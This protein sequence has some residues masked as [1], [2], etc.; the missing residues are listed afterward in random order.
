MSGRSYVIELDGSHYVLG[1][2]ARLDRVADVADVRGDKWVISDLQGAM[3]R[4]MPVEAP[5]RYV[6][7]PIK[8]ALQE[9]GEFGGSTCVLVHHKRAKSS[10]STEVFFTA[11]DGP[12]CDRYEEQVRADDDEHLL[13]S[14]NALFMAAWRRLSPA[15]PVALI[16]MHG[17]YLDYAIVGHGRVYASGRVSGYD[18]SLEALRGG[19]P[20]LD[21]DLAH[22]E[23]TARIAL[24]EVH[25]IPVLEDSTYR[26][27]VEEFQQATGRACK[28]WPVKELRVDDRSVF[29]ALPDLVTR[30]VIGDSAV[31]P[32][33]KLMAHAKRWVMPALVAFG[34]ASGGLAVG[35]YSLDTKNAELRARIEQRMAEDAAIGQPDRIRSANY[36]EIIEFAQELERIRHAPTLQRI[37]NDL[38][39]ALTGNIYFQSVRVSYGETGSPRIELEGKMDDPFYV[40]SRNHSRFVAALQDKG[41]Q[42]HENR[43]ATSVDALTFN[44]TLEPPADE[45]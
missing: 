34:L 45:K 32:V 25:V 1:P 21:D 7:F 9:S 38:S 4:F 6:E 16:M 36:R 23:E 24:A 33:E 28:V 14:L 43:L 11:L 42:V 30:L 26:D 18:A 2:G 39:G 27:W 10:R 29:S 3:P 37:L 19:I 20:V 15:N 41:Y 22:I 12:L 13:F 44:M 35:A 5:A 17:R 8:K 40:A 31:G